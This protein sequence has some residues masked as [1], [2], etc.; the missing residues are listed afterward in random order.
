MTEADRD[1]REGKECGGSS[2]SIDSGAGGGGGEREGWARGSVLYDGRGSRAVM[3]GRGNGESR[4]GQ[5]MTG[6]GRAAEG[7]ESGAKW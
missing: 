6:V 3:G 1:G 7:G 2:G 4:L 5:Q